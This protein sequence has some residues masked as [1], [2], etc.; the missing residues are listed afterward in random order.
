MFR[1][2]TSSLPKEIAMSRPIA[3]LL[4]QVRTE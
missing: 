1:F 2:E 3:L 4:S